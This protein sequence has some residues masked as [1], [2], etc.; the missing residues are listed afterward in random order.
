MDLA[1]ARRHAQA[2]WTANPCGSTGGDPS[3]LEYF[4]EVERER[5]RQQPW[6][7]AFFRFEDFSAKRV[8]EIGTGHGTDLAQFAKAGA[9]CHGVDITDAHLKLTERNFALRGFQ[10]ELKKADATALPYPDNYFDAVY[11][12]G[13]LHHIPDA[14]A[15]ISEVL[16]V[17]KPSGILM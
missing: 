13:V 6:Q 10:V 7:H 5:Y 2:Q 3:T 4:L 16:R 1:D 15:V 11:S 17:L 12:F 14:G 9:I 8:L